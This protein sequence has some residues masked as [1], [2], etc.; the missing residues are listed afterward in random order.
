MTAAALMLGFM[1]FE[2]STA[3]ARVQYN[4]AF[5][6]MYGENFGEDAKLKCNV[7]HGNGGQNKKVNSEYALQIKEVLGEKNV[8]DGDAIDAAL[9]AAAEKPS[10]VEGKTYGDLLAEGILPK[11]AE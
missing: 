6:A 4:K 5:K 8:K 3:E 7:C 11:P 1:G 10:D 2:P 9:K